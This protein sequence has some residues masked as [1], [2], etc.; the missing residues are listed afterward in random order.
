MHKNSTLFLKAFL[1]FPIQFLYPR[2]PPT[3]SSQRRTQCFPSLQ[4]LS[5]HHS[6]EQ[7]L[8]HVLVVPVWMGHG[9]MSNHAIEKCPFG[10]CISYFCSSSKDVPADC[11]TCTRS[12]ITHTYFLA[13]S[14]YAFPAFKN[15][16]TEFFFSK[17]RGRRKIW[18]AS[19]S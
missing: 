1:P 2:H 14:I 6:W 7:H 3:L 19:D 11:L 16:S 8:L 10:V 9:L 13:L 12:H 5:A 18:L 17:E 15:N 4:P